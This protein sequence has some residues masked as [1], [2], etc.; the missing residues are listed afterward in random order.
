MVV[1]N[2]WINN[3]VMAAEAMIMLDLVTTVVRIIGTK[4]RGKLKVFTDCKAMCDVL[5]LDRTKASPFSL[6]G[7]GIISKIIQ[8]E[9]DSDIE[10]EHAH[11]KTRNDNEERG[12]AMREIWC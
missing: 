3:A 8:L 2:Q 6:D 10:F 5:I 11:V 7:G 4:G 12:M 9:N 1:S